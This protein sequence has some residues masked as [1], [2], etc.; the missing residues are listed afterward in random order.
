MDD[1]TGPCLLCML[2]FPDEAALRAAID[3]AAFRHGLGELPPGAAI[4]ADAMLRKFYSADGDVGEPA[5]A[6]PFSYVVRYHRPAEDERAFVEHYV[7]SHPALLA[8]LPRIRSVLC[9]F[10]IPWT[11]PNGLA[12]A[13]YMLGNEVAVRLDRRLQ[14]G[15]EVSGSPGVARPLSELSTVFRPQHPLSDDAGPTAVSGPANEDTH[16]FGLARREI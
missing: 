9:D 6:A 8:R 5:L 14:H 1:G 7:A 2:S 4:T 12:S 3:A 10:P 16:A 15:D 11:D 13:Q